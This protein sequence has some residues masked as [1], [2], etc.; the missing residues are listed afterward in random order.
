MA[1]REMQ[2]PQTAAGSPTLRRT[3][4]ILAVAAALTIGAVIGRETAGTSKTRAAVQ[5]AS[6]ISFVGTDS[7]DAV[8]RADVYR[9]LGAM[10]PSI[11]LVGGNSA[12][13]ARRAEVYKALAGLDRP[14]A[15]TAPRLTDAERR[16]LVY[17][18]V[19]EEGKTP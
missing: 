14:T 15:S 2:M 6:S 12:D 1:T 10:D 7:S 18:L 19:A 9:A 11:T 4:A 3:T 8:R 16:A 17:R 5:P 13:A